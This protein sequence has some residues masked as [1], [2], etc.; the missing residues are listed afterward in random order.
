MNNKKYESMC[1]FLLTAFL[2]CGCFFGQVQAQQE[3][4][5]TSA[6]TQAQYARLLE[7]IESN[8]GPFDARLGESLLSYGD[9]LAQRGDHSDA[10]VLLERA[11]HVT[12]INKGLYSE[13]QIE[14]V[15]RL[16]DCNVA[17]EH[18]D[19]VDENFRYLQLLYTR[20][21]ERGT[22]QWH[23]GIAQ[24]S[25]WYVVAINNNLTEDLSDHLREAHKLFK[26][27]LAAA[28]EQ[29]IVDEQVL[30]VLRH[31]VETTAFH[32]RQK[33][34]IVSSERIYSRLDSRYR[35]RDRVASLD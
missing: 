11:L 13:E 29:G 10:R 16:I 33:Q 1:T 2:T 18:W 5:L 26:Q 21:Y 4:Q 7:S 30:S 12:R 25:D 35:D 9:M 15:E 19:A 20:L 14:I 31:N 8:F 27:R 6:T 17:E 28:Q 3:N 23:H 32:L 34:E 22:D 24:V